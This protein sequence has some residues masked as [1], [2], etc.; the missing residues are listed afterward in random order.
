MNTP[1]DA[2]AAPPAS[3]PGRLAREDARI[4]ETQLADSIFGRW[5]IVV[6]AIVLSVAGVAAGVLAIS[7]PLAVAVALSVVLANLAAHWLVR[8]GR[9]APWHFWALMVVDNLLAAGFVAAL[10]RF[11]YLL[12]PLYVFS[13]GA[14]A[15]GTPRLARANL[16]LGVGSYLAAR[17]A[18]FVLAGESA[19]LGI[20]ATEALFVAA[21]AWGAYRGPAS[22][23]RRLERIRVALVR[24]EQGELELH[25]PTRRD[26]QLG[27]VAA[28]LGRTAEGIGAMVAEVQAQGRALVSFAE[29]LAATALQVQAS[30]NEVGNTTGE[31]AAEVD[32]QMAL[33]ER[34]AD[35][36]EALAMQN[37][38]LRDQAST[39]AEDAGHLV[40]ASDSQVQT[41]GEVGA[42]LVEIAGAFER[43]AASIDALDRAGDEIGG[44]VGS[45][46]TIARQTNLLALNAAIEAA[47]AG[48]HGRGFAVVAD[49]VRKLAGQSSESATEVE[50]VIRQTRTA[51]DEVR[52]QL[53]ASAATLGS[54]GHASDG[55]RAA[56]G[57]LVGGLRRATD[58]IEHINREA[59]AQAATMDDL[60]E[61]MQGVQ[62]IAR[63]SAARAEETA[64]A[65]E[66]QAASTDQLSA[67]S[68]QLLDMS[69]ALSALAGR[70]RTGGEAGP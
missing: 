61:A 20:V 33:I 49:E 15:L 35:A 66:Q 41:I 42:L 53:D 58:A 50:G 28:S 12:L 38:G 68:Q 17:V 9:F 60:L 21:L 45:I 47:R 67:T 31:L 65:A 59:A 4:L 32:R 19:P 69:I 39:S 16:L 40:R 24:L 23:T 56:L 63:R 44:F 70:F 14:Y 64:A 34:G 57:D 2:A 1:S 37:F 11:G 51:I 22:Y 48:E 25:L 46:G 7:T 54:V 3:D 8:S 13:T 29:Q 6:L 26:D 5:V 36:V 18:G 52:S 30:A 27:V 62:E 55:G 43:S 10:G